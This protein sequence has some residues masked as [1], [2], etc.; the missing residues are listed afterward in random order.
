MNLGYTVP[1]PKGRGLADSGSRTP[2]ANEPQNP[3]AR[4]LTGG[5]SRTP[6]AGIQDGPEPKDAASLMAASTPQG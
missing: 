3:R 6:R 4:G 1:E 2:R 5:G